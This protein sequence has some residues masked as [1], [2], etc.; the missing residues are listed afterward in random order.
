MFL[1]PSRCQINHN[2]KEDRMAFQGLQKLAAIAFALFQSVFFVLSGMY[3]PLSSVGGV[4]AVLIM[5]QV[6]GVV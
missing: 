2:L 1:I 4:N 3:G 5:L 6:R